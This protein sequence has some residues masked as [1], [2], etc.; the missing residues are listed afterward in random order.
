MITNNSIWPNDGGTLGENKVQI[1]D[2][3]TTTWPEGDALV[4]NFVYNNGDLVGF[5]DTKALITNESNSTII[6]Y[7][8][9][10]IELDKKLEDVLTIT[11][12]ER[13]KYLNINYVD[14]L[15]KGYK[16]LPYLETTGT[17]YI[18]TEQQ[19]SS[20]VEIRVSFFPVFTGNSHV[21]FGIRR[22][23]IATNRG[24]YVQIMS[25]AGQIVAWR[26]DNR[27]QINGVKMNRHTLEMS[28]MKLTLDGIVKSS[29]TDTSW[30]YEQSCCLGSAILHTGEIQSSLAFVGKIY[31][32]SLSENGRTKQNLIPALDETDTPCMF[33]TVS[34]KAFY[35]DGTG[36]FLYPGASS[37]V[38]TSD[39]DETFYAKKTEHGIKRLYKV[40]SDCALSK[41]EYAQSNDYKQLVEPP[42]PQNGYWIPQWTETE[43]QLIC[44]WIESE[45]P[46][47]ETI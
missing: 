21:L 6:P 27:M 29:Y 14:I 28:G 37:Q 42:M 39:L 46:I 4:G 7:D 5:I 32:F 26:H 9:V 44:N 24:T 41:D 35:N 22:N 13:C 34:N 11:K 16:R 43:S 25:T 33:D 38:V 2:G 3:I 18:D 1:P 19:L 8:F 12:G 15:P 36:D 47:E 40:P 31:D 45:A 17:Q 23:D 30:A 10:Q 20:S